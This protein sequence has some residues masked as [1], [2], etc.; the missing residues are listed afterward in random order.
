M[1]EIYASDFWQKRLTGMIKERKSML[2]MTEE[3]HREMR[4][5][6]EENRELRR[7]VVE[8]ERVIEELVSTGKKRERTC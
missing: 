7:R 4:R 6:E 2:K 8:K 1:E 5:V 3:G